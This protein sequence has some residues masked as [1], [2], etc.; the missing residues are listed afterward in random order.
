ML[1]VPGTH[2]IHGTARRVALTLYRLTTMV[3]TNARGAALAHLTLRAAGRQPLAGE[4]T[5][6]V[7]VG[8]RA[9]TATAHLALP[10]QAH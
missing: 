9:A 1:A 4:L 7:Q 5:A 10:P 2:S 8:C 3:T 6:R